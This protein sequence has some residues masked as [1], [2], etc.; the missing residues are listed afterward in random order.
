MGPGFYILFPLCLDVY[1]KRTRIEL[2]GIGTDS[3][4]MLFMETI[5]RSMALNSFIRFLLIGS[6][7]QTFLPPDGDR[8]L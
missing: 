6:A 1:L 7:V 5:F 3:I 4:R 8:F 2:K